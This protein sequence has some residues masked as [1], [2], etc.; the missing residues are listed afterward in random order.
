[1]SANLM[2]RPC[3]C[4]ARDT[5]CSGG[6]ML[7]MS[8]MGPGC[9][10]TRLSR[11]RLEL[12]SQLPFASS[13]YQCDWF[14]QLRNRV[15]NSTRKF[16]VRVFTQPGSKASVRRCA[17]DFRSSPVSGPFAG[18]SPEVRFATWASLQADLAS[19]KGVAAQDGIQRDSAPNGCK[20]CDRWPSACQLLL[21]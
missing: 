8:Q 16:S 12:F 3:S 5:L 20:W 9:V 10:K 11:E 19:R 7:S 2:V 14:P 21:C 6:Q 1:M 15:K 17:G 13:T 4:P 18:P